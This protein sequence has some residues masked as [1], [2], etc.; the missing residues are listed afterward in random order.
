MKPWHPDWS[1]AHPAALLTSSLWH[2]PLLLTLGM[3]R[4][5]ETSGSS[6]LRNLD[7]AAWATQWVWQ[8]P[9]G[10]RQGGPRTTHAGETGDPPAPQ[11][12]MLPQLVFPSAGAGQGGTAPPTRTKPSLS[13]S[14]SLC[15]WECLV[16]HRPFAG[17]ASIISSCH[18]APLLPLM[19]E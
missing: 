18:Q 5:L 8:R 9:R 3:N 16:T 2:C 15:P 14:P 7:A 19:E 4:P 1:P 11:P 6:S 17:F 10:S 13:P 12:V